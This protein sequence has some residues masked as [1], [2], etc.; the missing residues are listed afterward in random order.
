VR[1]VALAAIAIFFSVW[2]W[3]PALSAYP[4]TQGGDG[5]YFHRIVEAARFSV[6]HYR[7]LPL[8]NPFE[9][10]GVPLWD[11]PQSITAAPLL[12]L[13]LV[14]PIDVTRVME[15]WYVVH[16]ALGFVSMW[17]FARHELR[18]SRLPTLAAAIV[19]TF[20][21]FHHHH[22]AGGHTAFVAFLYL[23]LAFLLW[24]RA[25]ADLR[26]AVGLGLLFA[27][28]IFEG[29]VYPLPHF[30]VALGAEAITRAWPPRR[31]VRVLRAGLVVGA[32]ALIV[33]A[34]RF[35]P[36]LDQIRS[37]S[38]NLGAETDS[39][40]WRTFAD[41]F[42]TRFHGA[43]M[44]HRPEQ[45]YVWGEYAAYVGPA[46]AILAVL[47]VLVTG[48]E[49]AWMLGV[50]LFLG[51]LMFG[52]FARY[53]PWTIL[54][55][56]VFPFKEMRV[57][58]R[59][60]VEV[61]FFLVSFAGLAVE[62]TVPAIARLA[63]RFARLAPRVSPIEG[64]FARLAPALQ[65]F[66]VGLALVGAG[67][68]LGLAVDFHG[69]EFGG[70]PI[71]AVEA[72]P[73][74][75]IGGRDIASYLDQPRQNRGRLDCWDEWGFGAGAP[76][77]QGDVPQARAREGDAGIVVEVANRTQNTFTIDV[78][79][80]EPGVVLVNSTYDKG[81]R[82]SVGRTLDLD[83]ELA[84]EVPAGHHQIRLAYWPRTLTAGLVLTPLGLLACALYL[85]FP[86]LYRRRRPK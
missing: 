74:L 76:L 34:A 20:A 49:Y 6:R 33:G 64:G 39:I 11:N 16:S 24:R 29:A 18:L 59:F 7:E 72:S 47:G 5:P 58:S 36:V 17:L 61:T 13:E 54:K 10:G 26:M 73:R 71:H 15:L 50:M 81:W 43:H 12:W 65:T 27:W 19:W 14:L 82:T 51:A 66:L 32:V 46:I 21:G 53:A 55:D 79:A 48:V 30:V 45:Q 3:S 67:D 83:K 9:C 22:L 86:A 80:R 28:M 60:A 75:F 41:M 37:H 52:H 42:T 62:R 25:E 4:K 69:E 2:A 63:S 56:H 84:V 35:L 78:T 77:W 44:A 1:V 38:R 68:V 57:P 31:F 85:G 23:P 70:G 40:A 8:W